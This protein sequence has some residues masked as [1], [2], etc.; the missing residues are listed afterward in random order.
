MRLVRVEQLGAEAGLGYSIV[1]VQFR[2]S[3]ESR[4]GTIS[5]EQVLSRLS[6]IRPGLGEVGT[7]RDRLLEFGG[8]FRGLALFAINLG[9][10]VVRIRGIRISTEQADGLI[11]VRDRGL[12]FSLLQQNRRQVHMGLRVSRI[13]FSRPLEFRSRRLRFAEGVVC[14]TKGVVGFGRFWEQPNS[15]A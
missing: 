15:L 11:Q 1:R 13:Q 8:C 3:T 4:Q 2:C 10:Q 6:E 14:L 12:N 7:Q 5:V 9:P